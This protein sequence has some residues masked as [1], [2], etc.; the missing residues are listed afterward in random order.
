MH[1]CIHTH[2]LSLSHTLSTF[3]LSCSQMDG[4]S[5]QQQGHIFVLGATNCPWEVSK[6][7]NASASVAQPVRMSH[8]QLDTAFLRRFQKRVYMPLPD[9]AAR[10]SLLSLLVSYVAVPW[11]PLS[12]LDSAQERTRSCSTQRRRCGSACITAGAVSGLCC[13]TSVY[14]HTLI[15]LHSL[16]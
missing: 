16:T 14:M 3:E 1:T 10:V 11:R 4:I 8:S 6:P 2:T 12:H 15:L 5:E 13:D 9:K 7:L